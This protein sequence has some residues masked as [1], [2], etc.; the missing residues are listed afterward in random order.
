[1]PIEVQQV[2]PLAPVVGEQLHPLVEL[3]DP[4]E[5]HPSRRRRIIIERKRI[6]RIIVIEIDRQ[7]L[8]P[9]MVWLSDR[10]PRPLLP[11][12]PTWVR[13]VTHEPAA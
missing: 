5:P 7:L 9:S 1:V 6:E 10:Y 8:G 12:V 11:S 2:E 13:E 4:D 3:I